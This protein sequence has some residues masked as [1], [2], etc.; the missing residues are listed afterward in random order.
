MPIREQ[1]QALEVTRAAKVGQMEEVVQRSIDGGRSMDETEQNTFDELS[2]E[3]KSV[4]ADLV[5]LRELERLTAAKA[6]PVAGGTATEGSQSRTPVQ[7]VTVRKE[8]PKGIALARVVRCFAYAKGNMMQAEQIA[9][10]QYPD[11]Q[12]IHNIMKAAVAAGTTLDSAWAGALVGEESAVFADFVEF[13]RPQTILGQFGTGG[14]PSLNRVPFR[15]PLVGQTSGGAG[16]WVGEGKSKPLTK[17]DFA[18]STLQPV[19]VANIAVI[20]EE[21][22]KYSNPSAEMLI[23]NGL[24]DALRERMDIDFVD[25]TKAAEENV[26]PASILYGVTPIPSSGSDADAVRAD[27][28]ALMGEFIAANNTPKAGVFLMPALMAL[29]LSLMTNLA[30]QPEFPGIT[31]NGGTLM[32]MPVIV[33]EYMPYDSDGAMVALV[34]ASDI[35]LADEGGVA[36]DLSREASL[37]MSSTPTHD[38]DGLPAP[39]QLVSLWQTNNVGLRAERVLNWAK[40]RASA[41]AYL[42]GVNWGAPT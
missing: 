24:A 3:I 4:D 37:E 20:S 11:D 17:F 16:Y 28:R 42:S 27:V 21:L 7:R 18:R 35:Y 39:T 19:K 26:S 9:A 14:I 22:L 32:G 30:G 41:A 5:R 40:R 33:S 29:S 13:L 10:S 23:R 34:N 2:A 36:I 6:A 12:R 1:I 31:M 38:S 15:V 8:E 25:P